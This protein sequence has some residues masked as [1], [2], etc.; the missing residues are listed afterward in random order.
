MHAKAMG[1]GSMTERIHRL[2]VHSANL[3]SNLINQMLLGKEA[4]D[5]AKLR[6]DKPNIEYWYQ[7]QLNAEKEL[8]ALG[9]HLAAP[10]E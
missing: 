10:L 7:Y 8:Q 3:L 2:P 9:I 6:N 1:N 5:R 4:V